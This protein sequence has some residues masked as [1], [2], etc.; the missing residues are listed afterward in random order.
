MLA[1]L[2]LACLDAGKVRKNQKEPQFLGVVWF[3]NF[4]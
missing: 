2:C 4:V 1:L 3:G